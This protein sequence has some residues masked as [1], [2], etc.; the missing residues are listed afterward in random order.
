MHSIPKAVTK[1]EYTTRHIVTY[2]NFTSASGVLD[3]D[4]YPNRCLAKVI[5]YVK[6]GR[7]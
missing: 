3:I 4:D 7:T 6:M 1:N 5:T 2:G